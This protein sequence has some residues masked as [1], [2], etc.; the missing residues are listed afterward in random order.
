MGMNYYLK[1]KESTFTNRCDP[2]HVKH[3]LNSSK[4]HIGKSSGGWKFLFQ[5][6]FFGNTLINSVKQFKKIINDDAW[7]I[8]NED[9]ELINKEDFWKMVEFKQTQQNKSHCEYVYDNYPHYMATTFI[10]PEG[11]DFDSTEF[12]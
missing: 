7:E 4:L 8:Y 12:S 2:T 10:D 1:L 9:E 3:I 5:Q 11:Y 6:N